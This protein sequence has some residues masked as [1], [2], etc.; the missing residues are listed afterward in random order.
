[1]KK[2]LIFLLI[3]FV[4]IQF[5][6]IDQ[7]NPPVNKDLDFL[8]IKKTPK[9][10]AKLIRTSCYDCHSDETVYP[11]YTKIQP[12]GW[13]MQDHIKEGR[14]ELNFSTFANLELLRQA[15]KLNHAAHEVEEGDMPIKSYLLIHT[16]AKLN[17][18]QT[19]EIVDYFKSV[20]TDI[21]Q[22]NG[23]TD[24]QVNTKHQPH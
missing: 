12:V 15:K 16:D 3:V 5:F 11:W 6:R 24:E 4:I 17:P 1:M 23:I 20:K 18:E 13:F 14:K 22:A 8:T 21:M 19:R 10:T 7:T 9:S 2:I